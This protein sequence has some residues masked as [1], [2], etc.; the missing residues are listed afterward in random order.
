MALEMIV[1]CYD[2]YIGATQIA[3]GGSFRRRISR[4]PIT[5]AGDFVG[6]DF[7]IDRG[8]WSIAGELQAQDPLI[9]PTVAALSGPQAVKATGRIKAGSTY[10]Y[11]G[12]ARAI[13]TAVSMEVSD[14]APG[15]ASFS[16]R[17]RAATGI[18]TTLAAEAPTSAASTP[19]TSTRSGTVKILSATFTPTGGAAVTLPGVT[20]VSWRAQAIEM[21]KPQA[22]G[23]DFEDA[24]DLGG[25]RISGSID[26]DDMEIVS[27]LPMP[28]YLASLVRGSFAFVCRASGQ[29]ESGSPPANK[30]ITLPYLK[31]HDTDE[32]LATKGDTTASVQFD[33]LLRNGATPLALSQMIAVA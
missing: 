19:T 11:L 6:G 32:G 23:S 9:V 33:Q 7:S 26:L 16:F 29:D 12:I 24:V 18:G 1:D 25:W 15:T 3:R 13:L 8:P 17:N 2:T 31:F 10:R 22:A 21:G 27:S 5:A 14:N 4:P 30:T 20:K 28:L